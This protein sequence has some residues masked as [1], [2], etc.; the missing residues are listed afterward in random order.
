MLWNFRF[1]F[2]S[3]IPFPFLLVP[4]ASR[5]LLHSSPVPVLEVSRS[6]GTLLGF[7]RD[8]DNSPCF[9]LWCGI[10]PRFRWILFRFLLPDVGIFAWSTYQFDFL[11]SLD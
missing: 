11:E 6:L 10:F 8:K 1:A 2:P 9:F 3:P 4:V 7:H 5:Q